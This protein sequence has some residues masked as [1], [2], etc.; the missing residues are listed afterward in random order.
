MDN[1][2]KVIFTPKALIVTLFG[3]LALLV[4]LST[5][6][7]KANEPGCDNAL[8][9]KY[10]FAQPPTGTGQYSRKWHAEFSHPDATWAVVLCRGFKKLGVWDGKNAKETSPGSKQ[11]V[12]F[13]EFKQNIADWYEVTAWF[14]QGDTWYQLF[15]YPKDNPDYI[16]KWS[17]NDTKPPIEVT[18][19]LR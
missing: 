6:P 7:A 5:T 4:V 9:R 16:T 17:V 12:K 10:A 18:L 13:I 15:V 11:Y 14:R 1:S 19:F 8:N 2:V 3:I